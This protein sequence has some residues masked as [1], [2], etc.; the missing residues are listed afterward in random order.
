MI[1]GWKYPI[2][3]SISM[4]LLGTVCCQHT[5]KSNSTLGTHVHAM[6]MSHHF[7]FEIRFWPIRALMSKTLHQ[8]Q[9][10]CSVLSVICVFKEKYHL[11]TSQHRR[12]KVHSRYTYHTAR[13]DSRLASASVGS[14]AG[15]WRMAC[16]QEGQPAEQA[17][18]HRGARRCRLLRRGRQDR[19]LLHGG[20]Q[21]NITGD[22]GS[23]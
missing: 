21:V 11:L 5:S 22:V 6:I 12:L 23:A 10:W 19:G 13:L 7:D 18:R 17:R 3:N 20:S 14:D 4:Y 9:I 15:G 8:S 1:I 2:S 16:V